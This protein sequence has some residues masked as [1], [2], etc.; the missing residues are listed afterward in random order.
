[1]KHEYKT[2]GTC[3][4]KIY[5]DIRDGKIYS[6][7]FKGGCNGN[8][9]ALGLL[10]EGMDAADIVKRLKGLRCGWRKSSCGDQLATAIEQAVNNEQEAVNT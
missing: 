6:I 2:A 4:R 9:K 1:M 3:S 10:A 5:F 8:L 7:S